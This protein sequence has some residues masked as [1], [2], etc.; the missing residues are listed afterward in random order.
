MGT[1][2]IGTGKTDESAFMAGGL[3]TQLD[4]VGS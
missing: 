1:Y 3:A 4:Y 2:T